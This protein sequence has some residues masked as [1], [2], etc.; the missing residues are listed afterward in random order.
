MTDFIVSLCG[1]EEGQNV[2]FPVGFATTLY[3]RAPIRPQ[4]SLRKNNGLQGFVEGKAGIAWFN[5]EEWTNA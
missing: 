2:W 3:L 1:T 5:I 4:I